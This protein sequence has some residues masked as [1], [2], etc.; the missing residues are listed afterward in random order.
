MKKSMVIL[1]VI[2]L[3]FGAMGI[4]S[5][6]LI[7]RGGGLIYDSDLKITW[8]QDANYAET[9]GYD[10]DGFMY[11]N[12]A[13]A[14]ADQLTY[15]GY[16]NWRLPKTVDGAWELG[17]DGTTTGGYNIVT[18]EMGYMYYVNLGNLGLLAT[19]GTNPQTGWGLNNAGPFFNLRGY[20]W[21]S[22]TE[23]SHDPGVNDRWCFDFGY[24]YQDKAYF[25]YTYYA[26]AVHDGDIG[27]PVPEPTT[28]LLL[29]SG[30]VCLAG[31]R[32]KFKKA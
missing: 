7:N 29:G 26:W 1:W 4:A 28:M 3:V 6:D 5:A 10:Y 9:S 21:W 19:D 15:G 27:A 2:L 17:Y 32:R 18:S 11:W 8:L 31:F 24:G 13:V 22:G 12:E 20:S 30:L 23:Y 16:D 14:W 25:G